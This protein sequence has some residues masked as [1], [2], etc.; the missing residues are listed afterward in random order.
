MC[1]KLPMSVKA[2]QDA[3]SKKSGDFLSAL[4][5]IRLLGLAKI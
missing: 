5:S 3:L 4:N 2:P 1:V